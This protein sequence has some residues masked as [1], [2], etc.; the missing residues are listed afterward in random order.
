M[1]RRHAL[2]TLLA[3]AAL[4]LLPACSRHGKLPKLGPEDTILAFGDSLTYGTGATPDTAYPAELS[5]LIGRK[6]VNAGVPGETVQEAQPR[7]AKLIDEVQ[8]KLV[9]VCLGGNNFLR[10]M[11]DSET[12]A[13]LSALL[14]ALQARHL[15]AAL[16]GVPK[17]GWGLE[18]AAFYKT[19]AKQY[20]LPLEDEALADILSK[21]SLKSDQIHPN[22]AGYQQLAAAVAK[23]LRDA[24]AV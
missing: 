15:P 23:L 1:N 11:P 20:D 18:T 4:P 21:H 9:I 6:V 19:L 8:P 7:L 16:I 13:A 3:A 5:R 10:R 24:G 17:F 2:L 22:A 12:E 14:A